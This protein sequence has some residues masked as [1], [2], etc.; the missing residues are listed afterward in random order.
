MDTA[1]FIAA[2]SQPRNGANHFVQHGL[3]RIFQ[4]SDGVKECADAGCHWL[5]DIVATECIRSLRIHAAG[6]SLV[7]VK[8]KGGVADLALTVA[9]NK[10]PIWTRHIGGTDMPAGK[11]VFELVDEGY[12][13]AMSL[14]SEH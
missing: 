1:K 3:V 7:E 14:V 13:F 4:Y 11:W 12:R 2:Y 10:P 6:R 5:L 9:D 8:V